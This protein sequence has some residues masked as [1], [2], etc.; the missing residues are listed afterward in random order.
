MSL[1]YHIVILFYHG[2]IRIAAL[3]NS[4]ARLWI[5]GRKNI[6]QRLSN[7]FKDVENVIWFHAA[8]LGEFEQG[9]PVIEAFRKEYP[10]FKILLTFFSPSGYEIRKDYQ[11]ADFIYYLPIDTL[12]NAKKFIQITN[13]KL[14][15][16]I[17]YEFW[18]NYLEVLNKMKI[19][20]F[21]ISA[22]FRDDQHFF[23]SYGGWFR[24]KL[25]TISK[26]FVQNAKSESLLRSVGIDQ[27]VLSGDT[28]FD[29]V[30]EISKAVKS[31]PLVEKFSAGNKVILG[32]STW[33]KDEELLK[34]L[35]LHFDERVKLII[36][37]HEIHPDRIKSIHREFNDFKTINYSELN[38]E[39]VNSANI[40]IIDGMGFLSGL[41]QYCD[42]AF[43]GGGFGKGIHNTLEAATFGKP[44]LFGPNYLRFKEAVD[45]VEKKGA[46]PI[47]K[48][49]DLISQAERFFSDDG[50]LQAASLVCKNYVLNNKG[51]TQ[52]IMKEID[53]EIK[54]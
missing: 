24:K 36:A 40:L 27:V 10:D 52:L 19:P 8:S 3:F 20:T 18:F 44:I 38:E 25:K 17:K 39:N 14:A 33:L 54:R 22:I 11:D 6:F 48:E 49:K 34:K 41:Y 46:F 53:E 5:Q 26:F 21:V 50:S 42:F 9:R 16:F 37:P 12:L 23:K 51:A 47:E 28:R 15:V 29:R 4:K 32:G 30:F 35:M 13:P 45:L 7:D 1:I 43:I 31:F 2:F